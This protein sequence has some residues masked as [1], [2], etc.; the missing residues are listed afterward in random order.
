MNS[1]SNHAPQ[2]C[3]HS[4]RGRCAF[5]VAMAMS[6]AS[7]RV[8]AQPP[9]GNPAPSQFPKTERLNVLEGQG[10]YFALMKELSIPDRRDLPQLFVS[11]DSISQHYAPALK[12]ALLDKMNV[13]HWM[14]LPTRFPKAV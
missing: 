12:V 5:A 8:S 7:S 2:N 14:D 13:T 3:R 10:D 4:I 6:F 9:V 1:L 11:G